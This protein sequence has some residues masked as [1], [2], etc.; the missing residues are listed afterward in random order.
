MDV[1]F[2]NSLGENRMFSRMSSYLV[3]LAITNMSSYILLEIWNNGML[4]KTEDR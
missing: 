2:A 4:E 3:I 1:S